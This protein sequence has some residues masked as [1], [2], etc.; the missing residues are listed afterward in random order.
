MP[1]RSVNLTPPLVWKLSQVIVTKSREGAP[2]ARD[3][4]QPG[5]AQRAGCEQA[6][7]RRGS[8]PGFTG[9][10]LGRLLSHLPGLWPA[11]EERSLRSDEQGAVASRGPHGG[12]A[13]LAVARSGGLQPRKATGGAVAVG[14]SRRPRRRRPEPGGTALLISKHEIS[15]LNVNHGACGSLATLN[16]CDGINEPAPVGR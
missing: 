6:P 12:K 3:G 1:H 14:V 9:Q 4:V 2:S 13:A 7:D 15:F 11:A 5:P 10:R 16:K 8:W